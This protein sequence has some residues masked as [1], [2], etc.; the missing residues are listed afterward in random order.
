[1]KKNEHIPNAG[2]NT[3]GLEYLVSAG[4]KVN[5][6]ENNLAVFSKMYAY[7]MIQLFY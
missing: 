5:H 7:Q 4:E 6:V 3:E 1:M 2:K